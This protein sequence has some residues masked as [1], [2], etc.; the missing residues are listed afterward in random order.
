MR[1]SLFFVLLAIF[2]LAFANSAQADP[3]ILIREIQPIVVDEDCGRIVIADLNNIFA[4]QEGRELD[5]FFQNPVRDLN[6]IITGGSTLSFNPAA[7]FNLPD[8]VNI[9]VGAVNAQEEVNETQFTLA[10][11]P[12][13]D[14]PVV[15]NPIED[16]VVDED[17]GRVDIAD[18]N[19]VFFDVDADDLNFQIV[20]APE[21]LNMQIA[22][23]NLLFFDPDEDFVL[24][25]GAEITITAEDPDDEAAEDTF[26]ITIQPVG[27]PMIVVDP[28]AIDFGE[29]EID[30]RVRIGFEL[31][32]EGDA[33]LIVENFTCE[34]EAFWVRY[35]NMRPELPPRNDVDNMNILV[36]E[37]L[38]N[39]E[40]LTEDDWIGVLTLD[41][42]LAGAEQWVA[43]GFGISIWADDPQT[44][45]IDGFRQGEE[46]EFHYWI[47]DEQRE[48]V[49]DANFIEG[50]NRWVA[51]GFSIATL[52]AN[53][54][55]DPVDLDE[56]IEIPPGE[57]VILTAY[58]EPQ[59]GGRYESELIILSNDFR[60]EEFL[61]PITGLCDLQPPV[62]NEIDDIVVDEDAGLV[63]IADLDDVFID[64]NGDQLA[65][66]FEGAPDELFME[67][68]ED[69][70]LFFEA[71]ADYN[72]R[73]GAEIIISAETP[74]GMMIEDAFTIVIRPVND[75][76]EV[77]NPIDD[78]VFDANP[79]RVEIA[80]LDDV[81]FDIDGDELQFLI[82]GAPEE[83]NMLIDEDNI[84]SFDPDED[85]ALPDGIEITIIAEDGD[86]LTAEDVFM[87]T[88]NEPEIVEQVIE[89]VRGWNMVSL[90]IIPE[91]R[92]WRREEGP[93]VVLLMAQIIDQLLLVK[94]ED[95]L[96][97]SPRFNFNNIPF[98]NLQEAYQINVLEDVV[99]R[100][101]G[102]PIPLDEEI[103]LERGWNLLAYAP[104]YELDAS[105]PEFY[106]L[107][108]II[109][110]VIIAKNG[111]GQFLSPE[112]RFS[113]MPPWRP[114]QG[115]QINVDADVAF[116]YPPE[117]EE[118]LAYAGNTPPYSPPASMGGN[119][120]SPTVSTGSNMSL[121]L[122]D[123]SGYNVQPGDR[124]TVLNS[125]NSIVSE[126]IVDSDNRC[127]L[128]IWGDDEITENIDGFSEGEAFRLVLSSND[129]QLEIR[130]S[131]VILGSGLIY[132]TDEFTV[133][134]VSVQPPL[135]EE[136]YMST[137]YPNP[138]N[139]TTRI[140]YGLPEDAYVSIRIY[141]ISGSLVETV[142]SES[143][144]GGH[145]SV[146]WDAGKNTSGVYLVRIEAGR[147]SNVT[148][149]VLAR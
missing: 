97:Y 68:D 9:T 13:N 30:E 28:E 71:I 128:V 79:G 53:E 102:F 149:V 75:A 136:F 49:A 106:V 74:D 41:G 65:F 66:A 144:T 67:I 81:F 88:I 29:V 80:D 139:S 120:S 135:P 27:G 104:D 69:N 133:L 63:V 125:D 112:F 87:L 100:I 99:L 10:V 42:V 140:S 64:P 54:R 58:F 101:E 84:L 123:I 141:D 103:Q 21:E 121:L 91:D 18:L 132:K 44:P 43:D 16:I 130:V 40:A 116:V 93:D 22:E 62:V 148:K 137:A 6:M 114:G 77:V 70:I 117:R 95:G 55:F 134:N 56:P 7:D 127:G 73:D 94:D 34:N 82:E 12:V 36:L 78:Q 2:V 86:G 19:Q 118:E 48:V 129:G 57:S 72:L 83:L 147:Y 119:H 35:V 143:Q 5:F 113:N 145:Y 3:P 47:E 92:Y 109:E 142:V 146:A 60:G 32:N 85:F 38:I 50:N 8:G 61:V 31:R 1:T 115:Y 23:N 96:F 15:V 37:A 76:P 124:I 39:G 20:G 98:W 17:P 14:A 26:T 126:G 107:S 46:M 4:D 51:N 45:A 59:E 25:D 138:F 131:E 24:P 110:N 122:N 89:L 11:F 52:S 111:V 90:N 108:P 105:A 33:D